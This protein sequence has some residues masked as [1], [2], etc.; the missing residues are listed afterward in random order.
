[1]C[2]L[3]LSKRLYLLLAPL[4]LTGLVVGW[5]TY[6]GLGNNASEL[7][8]AR[9]VKELS[10]QALAHL[11]VQDDATKAMLLEP[12]DFSSAER[13]I[14]AYD[15]AQLAFADMESLSQSAA[16]KRLIEQA[17]ELDQ[18]QLRPLDES[19]L[20]V[21]HSQG[22]DKAKEI[23]KHN[24]EP[25]RARYESL[26][27]SVAE[28]AE[29]EAGA[30]SARVDAA[31]QRSLAWIAGALIAGISFVAVQLICMTR[32]LTRELEAVA[33]KLAS[34]A[35]ATAGD[36]ERLSSSSRHL[37]D[38]A[39][40][41]AASLEESSASLEEM[42]SM[43][44]RNAEHSQLAKQ[45]SGET[46]AAA[47]AGASDV[48]QMNAAMDEVRRSGDGISKI[49]RTIDEIA[50]Q[51]NILALNA[52]VEAARAGEAGLGFAVVADEV[53]SLAH[54]SA[55]AARE[56]ADKISDSVSKTERGVALSGRVASSLGE[57]VGKARRVD[58]L[59]GDIAAASHEQ[60]S[61]IQN[62]TEAIRQIDTLTQRA[63][64][65]AEENASAAEALHHQVASLQEAAAQL[66]ALIHGDQHTSR[67]EPP[68]MASA[69]AS[70]AAPASPPSRAVAPVQTLVSN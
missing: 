26:L 45:L 10:A 13:K 49:I 15:A 56:T 18:E 64:A 52:S 11:F 42:S 22:V 23:Y 31:N 53:R 51:T 35:C 33:S 1:M 62:T 54:R 16:L 67:N 63:T 37:A 28:A 46:R 17:R 29:Q 6:S 57:I 68:A 39:S 14:G 55:Q 59:V 20:D 50:F 2:S 9:K 32:R 7:I 47:E 61:G 27:R 30:A 65:S 34:S 60:S 58:E 3:S 12:E 4:A 36:A 19:L 24:Y 41:Q 69:R 48:E 40:Q 66:R 43:T 38:G 8:A 21:L 44:R 25:A 5:L 70:A